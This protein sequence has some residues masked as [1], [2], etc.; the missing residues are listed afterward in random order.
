M[1]LESKLQDIRINN[2]INTI[3][4]Y[5]GVK[6]QN[7][8]RN[9]EI[10]IPR[11]MAMYYIRKNF[12]IPFREIGLY[13]PSVKSV[14]GFKDHS[15]V[16]YACSTIEGYLTCDKEII[17]YDEDLK[18]NVKKLSEMSLLD[19]KKYEKTKTIIE[20]LNDLDINQLNSISKY[21]AKYYN[22]R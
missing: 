4:S 11:Q 12:N 7:P 19:F 16:L 9:T 13:F 22:K 21:V 1:K 2:I 5:F 17:K 20:Q 15:S 6:C 3:D 18:D 8:I 10:V 14:S